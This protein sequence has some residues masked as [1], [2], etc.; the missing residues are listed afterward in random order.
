MLAGSLTIYGG[1]LRGIDL[2][3]GQL[4]KG[5][6]LTRNIIIARNL[7]HELQLLTLKQTEKA[8]GIHRLVKA[9]TIALLCVS[10]VHGSRALLLAFLVDSCDLDQFRY[11]LCLR[12]D[13]AHLCQICV[14][15]MGLRGDHL[16]RDV[17][18]GRRH[19]LRIGV[20][21]DELDLLV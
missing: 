1:A 5:C 6:R 13:C 12:A 3:H 20:V 11:V 2:A 4:L 17:N 19:H 21:I 16:V 14:G 8:C 18:T 9:V 7:V 15:V 10:L